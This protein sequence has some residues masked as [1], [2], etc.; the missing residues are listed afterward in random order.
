MIDQQDASRELDSFC[1][2]RLAVNLPPTEENCLRRVGS[3]IP[4]QHPG[5]P[6]ADRDLLALF[7][8]GAMN[9]DYLLCKSFQNRSPTRPQEPVGL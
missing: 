3:R 2:Q 9:P 7:G 4:L 5:K 1:N 6:S 8:A